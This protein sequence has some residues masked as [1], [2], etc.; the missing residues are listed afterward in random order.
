MGKGDDNVNSGSGGAAAAHQRARGTLN[1][2][3]SDAERG[4]AYDPFR[5][6]KYLEGGEWDYSLKKTTQLPQT[7]PQVINGPR[8]VK[9]IETKGRIRRVLEQSLPREKWN[10]VLAIGMQ[11]TEDLSADYTFGDVLPN[12]FGLSEP[13]F[14]SR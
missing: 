1:S 4:T 13:R 8:G 11:E 3:P 2:R 9:M 6:E 14:G 10:W 5:I 12:L 7:Y